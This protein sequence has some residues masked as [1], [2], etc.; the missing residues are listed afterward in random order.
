MVTKLYHGK[1]EY[2]G[3]YWQGMML[4][5]QGRLKGCWEEVTSR[6]PTEIE[7]QQEL[8]DFKASALAEHA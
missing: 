5:T 4:M 6:Y 1:N 8:D 2:S 7:A 3:E